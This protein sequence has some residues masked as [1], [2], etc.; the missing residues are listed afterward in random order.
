[1]ILFE[2]RDFILNTE[3]LRLRV[4]FRVRK[5]QRAAKATFTEDTEFSA[6]MQESPSGDLGGLLIP[7]L[8]HELVPCDGR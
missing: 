6:A 2:S 4:F 3:T 5:I 8:P 7:P 1:M